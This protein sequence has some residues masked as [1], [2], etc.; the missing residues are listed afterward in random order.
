VAGELRRAV[1]DPVS[2]RLGR[3]RLALIVPDGALSLLNFSSLPADD[4]S[5]LVEHD[6]DLHVL[7]AERDVAV[8][9]PKAS[10]GGRLLALGA[11]D[12]DGASATSADAQASVATYRGALPTCDS[13]AA[14][15]FEALPWT[16]VEVERIAALW[17]AQAVTLT[18]E[19]ADEAALKRLGPG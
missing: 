11:P 15:Q 9:R 10:P 4:G 14:T 16:G 18:G 19:R 8:P 12:F 7:T 13:F 1:W 2:R 17:D 5:F 6:P 3:A